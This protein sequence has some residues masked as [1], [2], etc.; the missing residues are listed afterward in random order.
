MQPEFTNMRL[1][2][3]SRLLLVVCV[4]LF[5]LFGLYSFYQRGRIS[6]KNL[7]QGTTTIEMVKQN[8]TTTLEVTGNTF[9][10]ILKAGTYTVLLKNGNDSQIFTAVVGNFFAT[11]TISAGLEG[12]LPR[13]FVAENPRGCISAVAES[14]I[15]YPCDG[16]A[17]GI[18]FHVPAT[19]SSPTFTKKIQTVYDETGAQKSP[20]E[21]GVIED[22]VDIDGKKLLLA[23]TTGD[24]GPSH[25][26]YELTIVNSNISLV[27]RGSIE[28]LGDNVYYILKDAQVLTLKGKRSPSLFR[29]NSL[30]TLAPVK[31]VDEPNVVNYDVRSD[32]SSYL[33][34]EALIKAGSEDFEGTQ[35]G[36][37]IKLVAQ[38]KSREKTFETSIS[39]VSFCGEY[40]CA[41]DTKKSMVL[42][43]KDFRVVSSLKNISDFIA[44]DDKIYLFKDSELLVLNTA[45]LTGNIVYSSGELALSGMRIANGQI[46]AVVNSGKKEHLLLLGRGDFADR[47]LPELL[48]NPFIN[49]LSI[50]KKS[51]FASP[52]LGDRVPTEEGTYEYDPSVKAIARDSINQTISKLSADLAGYNFLAI[53]L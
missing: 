32:M 28:G 2:L 11:T 24:Y 15:S 51:I 40:I 25:N 17:S 9:D 6:I 31:E 30:D 45:T 34:N 5:L 53:G 21:I 23:Y 42:Y 1:R 27:L 3:M 13:E 50:Y 35:S 47:A 38:G 12:Q 19:K 39:K 36:S 44:M 49:T 20:E 37:T 16:P 14:Y 4:T 18:V 52:E 7:P 48:A 43:D 26:I 41:L 10:R 22:L 8:D 29:G 33:Y 46:F